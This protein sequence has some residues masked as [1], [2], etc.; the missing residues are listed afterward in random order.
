VI[1]TMERYLRCTAICRLK[2]HGELA[3]AGHHE[4]R[5]HVLVA[6]RMP[7]NELIGCSAMTFSRV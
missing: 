3:S 6:I 4:V 7:V 5:R 1:M 2:L